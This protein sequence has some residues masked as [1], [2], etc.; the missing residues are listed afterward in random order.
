MPSGG[1]HL[2]K[3]QVIRT[4]VSAQLALGMRPI[5]VSRVNNVSPSFVTQQRHRDEEESLGLEP[6]GVVRGRPRAIHSAAMTAINQ[7]I[8]DFPTA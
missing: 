3:A 7:F 5:D 1:S 4:T 2:R 8:Q 6:G